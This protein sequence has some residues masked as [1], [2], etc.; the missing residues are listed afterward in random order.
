MK[1]GNPTLRRLP[2]RNLSGFVHN[3]LPVSSGRHTES[4]MHKSPSGYVLFTVVT[5]IGDHI[6]RQVSIHDSRHAPGFT[7]NVILSEDV[8][9]ANYLA[10]SPANMQTQLLFKPNISVSNCP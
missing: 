1:Q 3:F 9:C 10:Q 5:D 6:H 2:F 7:T 4:C 8:C